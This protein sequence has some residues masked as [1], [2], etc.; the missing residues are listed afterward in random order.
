[1]IQPPNAPVNSIFLW[2]GGPEEALLQVQIKP[3]AFAITALKEKLRARFAQEMPQVRFSFEPSDIVS[4]VMSFGA[5]TPVEVR[6]S[7][8]VL[9]TNRAFAETVRQALARI[10]SL[11]DLQIKQ[12]LDY[13]TIDVNIDRE[14]AG[15]LGV[16]TTDISRSL[17]AA[18]SSSRFVTPVYWA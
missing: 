18:T 1:G 6:V 16:R 17:V 4:R 7:G 14:R 9:V 13:P 12:A 3:G 15:L 5:N 10:P 11:R 8:P 2:T